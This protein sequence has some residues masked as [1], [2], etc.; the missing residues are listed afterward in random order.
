[1][2]AKKKEIIEKIEAITA[3]QSDCGCG[4]D[5]QHGYDAPE[6]YAHTDGKTYLF[7][8]FALRG[9]DGVELPAKQIFAL[10]GGKKLCD[11]CLLKFPVLSN[12]IDEAGFDNGNSLA[13][14]NFFFS[15]QSPSLVELE[16]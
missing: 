15:M 8:A 14:V 3:P 11:D 12:F 5:T 4:E 13:V 2:A 1:M 10:A 7:K 9:S 6:P 16:D